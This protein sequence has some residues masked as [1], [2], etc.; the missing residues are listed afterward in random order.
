MDDATLLETIRRQRDAGSSYAHYNALPFTI[1][2]EHGARGYALY[3]SLYSSDDGEVEK[4]FELSDLPAS[5]PFHRLGEGKPTPKATVERV[6]KPLAKRIPKFVAALRSKCRA[7][8]A[9]QRTGG[10]AKNRGWFLLYFLDRGAKISNR[11]NLL[12]GRAPTTRP[13]LSAATRKA[14]FQL[15]APLRQLYQVHD[16]LCPSSARAS[17]VEAIAAS[18]LLRPL[19]GQP[20]LLE[21]Y[22]DSGGNRKAYAKGKYTELLDWDR[23]THQRA[24]EGTL[25]EFID[26]DFVKY[27]TGAD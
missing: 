18:E 22:C 11:Y 19:P 10:D 8:I 24:P 20:D 3:A 7:V 17:G 21:V 14:G 5:S 13:S 23:E 27:V 15:P 6:F 26:R 12:A 16:G 2:R 4:Y 1:V 9:L 25:W